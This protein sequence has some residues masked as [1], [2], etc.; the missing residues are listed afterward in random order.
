VKL[1]SNESAPYQL[2]KCRYRG[3]E[4]LCRVYRNYKGDGRTFF[5]TTAGSDLWDK[6]WHWSRGIPSVISQID[7]KLDKYQRIWDRETQKLNSD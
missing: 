1:M 5:A 3:H 6:G 4:I 7:D 2:I